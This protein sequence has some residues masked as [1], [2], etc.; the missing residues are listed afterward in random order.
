MGMPNPDRGGDHYFSSDPAVPSVPRTITLTLPDLRLS[1]V[2]DRGVFAGTGVDPGTKLLLSEAPAAP[3]GGAIL[4]LGCGYGPIAVATAV[5]S[6]GATIWAVDVNERALALTAENAA[7]AGVADRLHACRPAEVP[8]DVTFAA[9]LSNP[10]IRIGKA[11]LQLLLRTWLPRLDPEVGHAH[12]V[13]HKHLG[14]D[15][16]AR[17]LEHEGYAVRRLVSRMGYRILEVRPT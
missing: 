9:I 11:A 14:S 4:D 8:E 12:L 15:S 13:V 7:N 6:P 3:A 2:T 17:W 1:L 5:R 10:P 16:L